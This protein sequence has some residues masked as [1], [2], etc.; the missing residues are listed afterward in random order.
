MV[1][2]LFHFAFRMRLNPHRTLSLWERDREQASPVQA[3]EMASSHLETQC[4]V[5]RLA[6]SSFPFTMRLM[7]ARC[8]QSLVQRS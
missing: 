6:S 4:R 5:F 1:T 7:H 2:S 3:A 8:S